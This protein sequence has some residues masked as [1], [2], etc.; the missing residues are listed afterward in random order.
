MVFP[1]LPAWAG[2]KLFLRSKK[3]LIPLAIVTLLLSVGAGTYFYLNHQQEQAV[4]AAVKTA[5]DKATIQTYETKEIIN[6]RTIEVDRR[7]DDLQ[8]QTIKDYA[9]V[10][11][12]IEAAPVEERDAQAPALIIDTLN[13]LDRLRQRRNEGGVPDADV[14]VG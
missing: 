13:E 10:R 3:F 5:D 11:N 2:I 6:T 14:P 12:Q 9:N 4:A 7:F 8:R 1:A